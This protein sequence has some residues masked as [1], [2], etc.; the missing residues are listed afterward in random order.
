MI[1]QNY[2]QAMSPNI[3]VQGGGGNGGVVELGPQTTHALIQ[4]LAQ[5][6]GAYIDGR[7][8]TNAINGTN[9]GFA[10]TGAN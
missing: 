9:R 5:S 1:H 8:V 4:A 6:G 3:V 2:P 7:A 10:R